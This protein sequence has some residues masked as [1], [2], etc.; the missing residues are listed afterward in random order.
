MAV[1]AG[2]WQL[3]ETSVSISTNVSKYVECIKLQKAR[4]VAICDVDTI[5][6]NSGDYVFYQYFQKKFLSIF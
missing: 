1:C 5:I 6:Y 3:N 2:Y 4:M